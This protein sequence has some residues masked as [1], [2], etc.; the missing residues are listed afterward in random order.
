M[1]KFYSYTLFILALFILNVSCKPNQTNKNNVDELKV[2][3]WNIWHGGHQK[4]L[5]SY[6]CEGTLGILKNSD[7]D[8]ILMIET[9]GASANV[10]DELGYYHRLI[11][12]NL[13]I[14]SRYPITNTYIF[15]DSIPT[16]NFGGAEIDVNGKKV[17]VFDTWLTY[18]ADSTKVRQIN[19]ILTTLAPFIAESNEIPLI[20]GGDFNSVSHLDW[21]EE[22]KNMYGHN[23]VVVKEGVSKIMIDAGFKDSFREM[24]PDPIKDV[25][26]TWM[27]PRNE[28]WEFRRSAMER[29]GKRI[30]Y[31]EADTVR[32]RR[33]DYIYYLGEKL[34]ITESKT[35]NKDIGEM[36]TLKGK[37]FFFAS[38]HG[39]VL[40]TFDLK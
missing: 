26:T 19:T 36:L 18:L 17:R 14:Y 21:T 33:I 35:Y 10:A 31:T 34:K 20:I 30:P 37:D 16:F 25:G 27:H 24:N 28:D 8:V 15:P 13:S 5:P 9:Y 3:V 38:D 32:H 1:K 39:I 29:T 12:S 6:G 4:L 22:T 23:G 11:S 2:L 40:T 7:A